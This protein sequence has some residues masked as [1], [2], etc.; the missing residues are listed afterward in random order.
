MKKEW[1]ESTNDGLKTGILF[2]DLSAALDTTGALLLCDKPRIV[3]TSS[4]KPIWGVLYC[5]NQFIDG[6]I[7]GLIVKGDNYKNCV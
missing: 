3:S 2:W 6:L 5:L 7:L 4:L 1:P